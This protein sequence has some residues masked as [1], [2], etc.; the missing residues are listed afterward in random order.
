MKTIERTREIV[1]EIPDEQFHPFM[2]ALMN[3]PWLTD[4][5]VGQ[6]VAITRQDWV[7]R[8]LLAPQQT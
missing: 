2:R 7:R 5:T 4:L 6:L 8:C 1:A 3:M